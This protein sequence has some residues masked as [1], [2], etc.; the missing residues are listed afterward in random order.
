MEPETYDTDMLNVLGIDTDPYR[1]GIDCCCAVH[2]NA[3]RYRQMLNELKSKTSGYPDT[4]TVLLEME[5]CCRNILT[6][7]YRMADNIA[8]YYVLGMMQ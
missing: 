5:G 7:G 8:R 6:A 2:T 3:G 4:V 1:N